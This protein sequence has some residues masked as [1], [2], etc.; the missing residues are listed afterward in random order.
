MTAES[1]PPHLHVLVVGAGFGGLA[2][3]HALKQQGE[4]FAVL[5]R[6]REVGGV[7]RDNTYPGCACDIPSNLYSLSF[8]PNPQWSQA[9]SKQ[10]EIRAYLNRVAREYG[11]LPHIRF[12]CALHEASWDDTAQRWR[13][14]TSDGP[15]TADVLIDAG[16]PIAEPSIP[17]LPGLDRFTGAVFHS[18]RWDHGLDLTGRNVVVVGT[19]AS[20]IQFVPA[21]QPRVGRM[22]VVQRTPPW[23]TPRMDRTTTRFERRLYAAAPW[24]QQV[25]RRRQYLMREMITWKIM[26]SP[27]VRRIATKA[28]LH[29]LRRQVPDPALRAQLTP[30]FE[31]GC[32]RILISNDWYPALTQP[33]VEVVSSGVRE[34]RETSVVTADGREHPADV[35]IFGTG[36]H[37]NDAPM[38]GR[39]RGRDGRTLAEYWNGRPRAYLGVTTSNFPNLFRLGCAGSATGHNSHVFQEECQVAY[40]MDALRLMRSRAI[41]AVEVRAEAQ[42]AYVETYTARLGRTVWAVGGC[43]SWYQGADGIPWSNWPASTRE[44]RRATRR[45]DPAPYELRTA[46]AI[47]PAAN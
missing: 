14:E 21:I 47:V 34:V 29:H 15:L 22:T 12:G 32:K 36:F 38:A 11:L 1:D 9:F 44:Y 2:A 39:L 18:A 31:L 5:E 28:A 27:R 17:D 42:E 45:F 43:N 30:D 35:I 41:A 40:A 20:A 4:D 46:P 25:V 8:A 24:L 26:I 7:W 6:A 37:V 23:I 33:N 19:G 16:G 3:A 10:P 13:V